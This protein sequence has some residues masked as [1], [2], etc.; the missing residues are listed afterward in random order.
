[1]TKKPPTKKTRTK[2]DKFSPPEISDG[3]LHENI[4]QILEKF[5]F[6]EE[7]R[8]E[9]FSKLKSFLSRGAQKTKKGN[10]K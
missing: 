8:R 1:M 2:S 4:E 10:Q 5:E 3:L 7:T 9:I 6:P